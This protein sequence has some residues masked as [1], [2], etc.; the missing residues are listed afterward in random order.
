MREIKKLINQNAVESDEKL[1]KSIADSER[2][3]SEFIR[4]QLLIQS[5]TISAKVAAIL[6]ETLVMPIY[7]ASSMDESN[8]RKRMNNN[9][10]PIGTQEDIEV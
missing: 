5:A 4:E 7:Q 1:I 6:Q 3:Q 8:P 9:S 10:P 2:K